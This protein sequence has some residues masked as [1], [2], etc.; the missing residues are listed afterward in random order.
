MLDILLSAAV[1]C[2][3]TTAHACVLVARLVRLVS[4]AIR[5]FFSPCFCFLLLFLACPGKFPNAPPNR[6][7]FNAAIDACGRAGQPR[8]AIDLLDA[9]RAA[10]VANSRLKPDHYSYAGALQACRIAGDA[11]SALDLLQ[12]LKKDRVKLDQ[13]CALA[14]FSAV[15]TAGAGMEDEA[16]QILEELL[17]SKTNTSEGALAGAKEAL[18]ERIEAGGG[19]GGGVKFARAL[20]I[21]DELETVRAKVAAAKAARAAAADIA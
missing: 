7:G 13:R 5:F 10:S 11:A 9:M 15:S 20:A 19:G 21:L 2:N 14:A 8:A 17:K 12:S 18:V 16:A 6:Q 3:L 4:I 1:H